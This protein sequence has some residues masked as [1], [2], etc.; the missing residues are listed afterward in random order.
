[1]AFVQISRV[2]MVGILGKMYLVL[3][4]SSKCQSS[5]GDAIGRTVSLNRRDC[6]A[7]KHATP[8]SVKH[9]TASYICVDLKIP[10]AHH[11]A[12]WYCGHAVKF[13]EVQ[14]TIAIGS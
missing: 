14:L 6:I 8:L 11:T 13:A 2:G 3:F 12:S 9:D 5:E 1:M 10:P 7:A 4:R